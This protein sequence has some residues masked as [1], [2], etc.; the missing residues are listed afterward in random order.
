MPPQMKSS[1]F[2]K[3]ERRPQ[4]VA[5]DNFR[6]F[7]ST[8]VLRKFIKFI[9]IYLPKTL[10]FYPTYTVARKLSILVSFSM[11]VGVEASER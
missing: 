8:Q 11:A 3:W 5:V 9:Y 6:L 2:E 7:D 4:F 1:F 10:V